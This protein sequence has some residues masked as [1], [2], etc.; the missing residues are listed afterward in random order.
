MK[1]GAPAACFGRGGRH[2]ESARTPDPEQ[3]GFVEP[4]EFHFDRRAIVRRMAISGVTAVLALAAIA[5]FEEP[6][7]YWAIAVCLILAG[8]H[9]YRFVR[10]MFLLKNKTPA[11]V[12]DDDGIRDTVLGNRLIPWPAV[13]SIK[14]TRPEKT[15]GG[16]LFLIADRAMIGANPGPVAVRAA[17]LVIRA[18]RR[19]ESKQMVLAMTPF[20]IVDATQDDILKA[21]EARDQAA[22]IPVEFVS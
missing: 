13:Q 14:A 3:V 10:D 21:V 2:L 22:G 19:P 8:L 7:W 20:G 9:G 12:V 11:I 1:D 16:A 6:S 4:V 5:L 15:F 18:L 17:N